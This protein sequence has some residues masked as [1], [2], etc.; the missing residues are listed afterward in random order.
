MER[1]GILS[2]VSATEYKVDRTTIRDCNRM[3]VL[4]L[5]FET[6]SDDSKRYITCSV[7]RRYHNKCTVVWRSLAT[8]ARQFTP[9]MKGSM[10]A[11]SA[12]IAPS[13]VKD[14]TVMSDVAIL[15]LPV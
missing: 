15:G 5:F 3:V 14:I 10:N 4:P 1:P 9:C 13:S 11:A 12:L 6:Y 7:S 8:V 2:H